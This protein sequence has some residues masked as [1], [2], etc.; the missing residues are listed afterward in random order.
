MKTD[1]SIIKM[2]MLHQKNQFTYSSQN[3]NNQKYEPTIKK[4]KEK[5]TKKIVPS[6]NYPDCKTILLTNDLWSKH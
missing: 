4:L 5:S 2:L 3:W 1:N 6:E